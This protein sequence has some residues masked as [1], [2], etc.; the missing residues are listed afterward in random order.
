[1]DEEKLQERSYIII[2]FAEIGSALFQMN[3]ENISPAQMFIAS[4]F[5]KHRAESMLRDI[6]E[7]NRKRA[8]KFKIMTPTD[9]Q[10]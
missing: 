9:M 3:M 7:E 2:N 4:D 6:E 8:E 5:I 1:M 10:Q